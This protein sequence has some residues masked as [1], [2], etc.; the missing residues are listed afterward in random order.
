MTMK[1]I[2]I[3]SKNYAAKR[4]FLNKIGECQY[5]DIRFYNWYLWKNAHLWF[6]RA[7]GKLNMTPEEAAAKLFY[8]YKAIPQL[9]VMYS[10]S[11]ILS[12]ILIPHPIG[13]LA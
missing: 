6:L 13:L 11:L 1:T 10:I 12:I 4:L 2:G 3:L 8:D 7:I 5:K 9:V